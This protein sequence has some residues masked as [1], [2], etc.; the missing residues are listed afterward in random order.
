MAG[1]KSPEKHRQRVLHVPERKVLC[2]DCLEY[3]RAH[4]SVSLVVLGDIVPK[5]IPLEMH[6]NRWNAGTKFWRIGSKKTSAGFETLYF[7]E[8]EPI[9]YVGQFENLDGRLA[10]FRAGDRP[11]GGFFAYHVSEFGL[12][13][14]TS[15]C[16][17]RVIS[18]DDVVV[19][20]EAA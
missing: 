13:W 12:F 10:L 6:G 18:M 2:F 16:A 20:K 7:D 3:T 4:T 19:A 8:F 14:G 9:E 1:T 11:A 15:S 17:G 5:C